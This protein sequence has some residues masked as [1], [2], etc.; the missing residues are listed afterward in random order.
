MDSPD[1]SLEKLR[2]NNIELA[3]A[4]NMKKQKILNLN[5]ELQ[6]FRWKLFDSNHR[7][8]ALNSK[9]CVLETDMCL[10]AAE[11]T[12]LQADLNARDQTLAEWR[13]LL[14]GLIQ[15]T[16]AK[17][18]EVMTAAGI[19][20]STGGTALPTTSRTAAMN[21]FGNTIKSELSSTSK[22]DPEQ[23]DPDKL[24]SP[25]RATTNDSNDDSVIM[26]VQSSLGLCPKIEV[27]KNEIESDLSDESISEPSEN[28]SQFTDDSIESVAEEAEIKSAEVNERTK[29]NA[30]PTIVIT[31]CEDVKVVKIDRESKQKSSYGFLH[32]PIKS[33]E[34]RKSEPFRTKSPRLS[35]KG[36]KLS[37]P[38]PPVRARSTSLSKIAEVSPSRIAVVNSA[39]NH[40]TNTE[41]KNRSSNSSMAQST[42]NSKRSFSSG[43]M[44]F[45]NN[46]TKIYP[47]SPNQAGIKSPKTPVMN[48]TKKKDETNDPNSKSCSPKHPLKDSTNDQRN[49]NVSH[50]TQHTA[51]SRKNHSK[52]VTAGKVDPVKP[53]NDL[54][55]NNENS[56][57]DCIAR[58]RP[59]RRAAPKD[60]REPFLNIKLR[61]NF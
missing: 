16:T 37:A 56:P 50:P 8:K 6:E 48:S 61:R 45:T 40:L 52:N 58:H 20:P 18:C 38:V 9:N 22:A 13:Q 19:W 33:N 7:W 59:T 12:R 54:G 23:V 36:D 17:Y 53:S 25:E 24:S 44:I 15:G 43:K 46:F 55:G 21:F 39:M 14:V 26:D 51:K 30:T 2:K 10:I 60:L 42:P 1:D 32:V 3:K 29:N 34:V 47:S 41:R 27:I 11:N 35:L 5:N 28:N 4:L 31:K 49:Q 57:F